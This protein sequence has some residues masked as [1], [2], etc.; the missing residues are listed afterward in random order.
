M[1]DWPQRKAPA[2]TYRQLLDAT[3][4]VSELEVELAHERAKTAFFADAL[5]QSGAAVVFRAGRAFTL[6]ELATEV[7][8]LWAAEGAYQVAL[9]A[10]QV[11]KRAAEGA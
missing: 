2:P 3:R 1:S 9:R 11:W 5:K 6:P 7:Q 10:A 8:R 4:R